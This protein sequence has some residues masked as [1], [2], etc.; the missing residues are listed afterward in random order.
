MSTP[1]F[2]IQ[3][4]ADERAGIVFFKALKEPPEERHSFL[5]QECGSDEQL[6]AE[7][8]GLLRDHENAGSF[9][10]GDAPVATGLETAAARLPPTPPRQP[11]PGET[12]AND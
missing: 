11:S 10:S 9:L 1:L 4:E 5:S 8:E 2:P 3:A 7:V 6:R 12:E